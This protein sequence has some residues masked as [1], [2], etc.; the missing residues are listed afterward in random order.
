MEKLCTAAQMKKMDYIAMHGRY[1]IQ[2][3]VLMENAGRA[4]V[5]IASSYIDC[6]ENKRIALFCGKGNNG[7]DGFVIARYLLNLGAHVYVYILGTPQQYSDEAKQHLHTLEE[8]A[9][10]CPCEITVYDQSEET[11]ILLEHR[12]NT[13]DII[14]DAMLGTGFKG[15]LRTPLAEL[16]EGINDVHDHR[17]VYVIAV[18]IPTGIDSDTGS[19]SCSDVSGM[20]NPVQADLTVTFGHLKRG[21]YFYPG[22]AYSGIIESDTIGMPLSLLTHIHADSAFLLDIADMHDLLRPRSPNS[23]K[24]NHGTIAIVSG[25][26]EMVGAPLM[27]CRGAL[28]SGAGKIFLRIPGECAPYC[29]GKQPEIMGKGIGSGS[30]FSAADADAI[31]KESKT[32]DAIAMGPGMGKNKSTKTFI[33]RIIKGTQCP[34]IL[35]AD[36]LNLLIDEKEFIKNEGKRIIMTPHMGEFS[37]LAH[38]STEIIKKDIIQAAKAF[39]SDWQVTLVLKGA[40]TV[41]VDPESSFVFVNPT[42]NAGM[43]TGGM[44]DILTGMIS[45]LVCHEGIESLTQG[46]CAGVYLHGAAG[47]K[48]NRTYGPYGYSP[49]ELADTI[50]TILSEIEK[51]EEVH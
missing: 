28:R 32:W 35:D 11:A 18:D 38:Q 27:S 39:V 17:H 16:A 9:E 50:P 23:H 2:P 8:L 31:L 47:D 30:F 49:L 44:G 33:K 42:G 51:A 15:N 46:A 19:V 1:K 26:A 3:A 10:D 4:V 21:L 20:P 6:W 45:A 37:R 40:P 48:L 25:C 41:V 22:K 13:C 34:I 36:A 24:G 43:A 7:G 5:S 12:L 14:I 29:I